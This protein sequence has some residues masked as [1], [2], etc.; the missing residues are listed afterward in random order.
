[1]AY[2]KMPATLY[3]F[4]LHERCPMTKALTRSSIIALLAASPALADVTPAQVWQ[5]Q[6]EYLKASGYEVTEGAREEAGDTLTLTDVVTTMTQEEVAITITMPKVVLQET[7]GGDVRMVHDA[8]TAVVDLDNDED[9]K[10]RLN[11]S[12]DFSN[13][14]TI[15]SGDE[16]D[17]TYE[18]NGERADVAIDSVVADGKTHDKPATIALNGLKG[19]YHVKKGEMRETDYEGSIKNLQVDLNI[20]DLDDDDTVNGSIALN[21]I[22]FEGQQM[23]PTDIVDYSKNIAAALNKGMAA[24]M[25][26]VFGGYQGVFDYTGKDNESGKGTLSGEA[27]ELNLK[28]GK[29]G[30]VYGGSAGK[31][32]FEMTI[33]EMPAPIKY[34]ID[35]SSFDIQFPISKSDEEQPF[36]IGYSING[37]SL[38]EDIWSLF[39]P[40]ENLPRDPVS[41]VL[42]V[43]GAAKIS[44]DLL[45]PSFAKDLEDQ[46]DDLEAEADMDM[47]GADGE[48]MD[49]DMA[50]DDMDHDMDGTDD[51]LPIDVRKVTINRFDLKAV[52]AHAEASGELV[53]PEGGT[54]DQPIGKIN[55]TYEGVNGLLD[56]L[57]E[58]GLFGP[59][60]AMGYRMMMSAFAKPVDGSDDKLSTELEFK[61]DNQ[62]FANGQRIQ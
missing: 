11:L 15:V 3:S 9:D 47:P 36:K 42:D 28:I 31:Q 51:P 44:R 30:L 20:K 10:V 61:E 23:L 27:G 19:I 34:A 5:D 14:E 39:D 57:V 32:A 8:W 41:L 25:K 13:V 24:D 58:M 6:V 35:S 4:L 26:L 45:D 29:E 1:M 52:G 43:T 38:N 55:A 17:M 49:H 46:A 62:I 12:G 48:T 37:M 50:Q 40:N 60:D 21:D 56:A 33:S 18:S 54:M 2:E 59:E 16:N 53:A 22:A 7:G